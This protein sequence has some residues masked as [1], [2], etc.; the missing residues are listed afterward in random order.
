MSFYTHE[1]TLRIAKRFNNT[2]RQYLLVNPL[3]AKHL[4]VRPTVSLEMMRALGEQLARK[5]PDT[6]LVIGFAET[7]TA[8]G[9]AVAGCCRPGCIY[10]QTTREEVPEVADW[11]V[12][13]EEHSHAVE[14]KLCA[15]HLGEWIR[16]TD[17]ILFVD[18]EISTGKTLI[19]MI[20]QLKARFPLLKE[21]KLVAASVL[22]RVS[23]ENQQRML[24]MGILSEYLVKLPEMDYSA[25]V[26]RIA[27]TQ[28]EWAKA[29]SHTFSHTELA[30]GGEMDPRKGVDVRAFFDNC[31]QMAHAFADR[32]AHQIEGGSSVLLLGTEECMYPALILGKTLEDMDRGYAVS[33]HATTRSPIGIS[34]ME[35]YPVRSGSRI[36]SFYAADR[37]TYLYNLAHY[38][39]VIVV[40]DTSVKDLDAMEHLAGAMSPYDNRKFYYVQGG[41]DVW[42]L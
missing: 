32:F 19:N 33:C 38:D 8:I 27:V 31:R 26:E 35:G 13:L 5:Y 34:S 42:Y 39:V 21:K 15:E 7:A 18:D 17:T 11:V 10:L 12:F 16:D 2:K 22:N 40:S 25:A 29:G 1:N 9:A 36:R 23:Q 20:R 28:A 14:Q 3:Q 30:C 37:E 4:P 24:E 41:Q 6:G